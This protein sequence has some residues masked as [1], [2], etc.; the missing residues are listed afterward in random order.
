[1]SF[2]RSDFISGYFKALRKC[3]SL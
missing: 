3:W 1:M 2:E